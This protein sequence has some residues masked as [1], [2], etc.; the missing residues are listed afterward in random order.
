MSCALV[1]LVHIWWPQNILQL[2]PFL[3]PSL[4]I[5]DTCDLIWMI[6]VGVVGEPARLI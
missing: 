3:L 1:A 2:K 5:P 6:L 4:K